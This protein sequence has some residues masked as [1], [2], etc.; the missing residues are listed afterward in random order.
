[1]YTPRLLRFRSKE[2][3][4]TVIAKSPSKIPIKELP[5]VLKII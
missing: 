5:K 3:D 2:L 4:L 1:M